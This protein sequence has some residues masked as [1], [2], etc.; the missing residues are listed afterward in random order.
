MKKLF[1]DPFFNVFDDL[2]LASDLVYSPQVKITKTGDEYLI[3]MSVPGLTKD[4]L[5]ISVKEH[6]LEIT[7]N[8]DEHDKKML[9]VSSFSK[10]YVL[11]ETVQGEMITGK[12]ENGILELKIPLLKKQP[13]E[14][15]ISL[16]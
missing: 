5:K 9:F 7:Y 2:F 13:I 8:A 1:N 10:K 12:V 11:P 6:E 16:N 4:D 14:R 15:L 3:N